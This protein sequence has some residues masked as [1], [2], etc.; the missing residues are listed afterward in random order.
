MMMMTCGVRSADT[1]LGYL[2]I[3]CG[4]YFLLSLGYMGT[5]MASLVAH[6]RCGLAVYLTIFVVETLQSLIQN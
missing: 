4:H 6:D 5:E 3:T 2:G 1:T